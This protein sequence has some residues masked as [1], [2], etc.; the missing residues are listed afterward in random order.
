MSIAAYI[1]LI[2]MNDLIKKNRKNINIKLDDMQYVCG[3]CGE[4]SNP[5]QEF[6]SKDHDFW[7][8]EEDLNNPDLKD[9]CAS[10][11]ISRENLLKLLKSK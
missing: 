6:C 9:Y 2:Y 3:K 10:A 8:S 5:D 4:L 11:N 1:S 7:I